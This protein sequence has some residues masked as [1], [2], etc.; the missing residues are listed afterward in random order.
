[1]RPFTA[2]DV[3]SFHGREAEIGELIGRLRANEREIFVIGPSGSG[4]SSLVAAGLLPRLARGLSGLG[5]FVV[6]ELRPGDRPLSRLRQALDAPPGEPLAAAERVAA[7]LV[8]RAPGT[9]VLIIVDQLEEL[10][11]QASAGERTAFLDAVGAMRTEL[12]CVV[13]FTLRADFS[14]ALMESPLWPE[15]PAQISRVDVSPLRGKGLCCAIAA[16]A[17]GVGVAVQPEL[18]ERLVAD[19]ASEPG[20]LPFLQETMVQLWDGRRDHT[21]ALADY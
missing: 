3:A 7:L 21:L 17:E 10:F 18:I 15:R 11:T 5:P 19:A 6:R 20:S 8:H 13:I 12:R 14:E 2:E 1:M 16:P 4:K 9:S